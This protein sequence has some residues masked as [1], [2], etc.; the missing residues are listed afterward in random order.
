M[1]KFEEGEEVHRIPVCRHIFNKECLKSW[2]DSKVQ[3]DEQRCPQ[4]N[5]ILKTAEMQK[6][7]LENERKAGAT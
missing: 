7:R 4:C 2:F 5:I 3:E 6:K 1:E